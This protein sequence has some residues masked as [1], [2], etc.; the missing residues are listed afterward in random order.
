[1][2][3]SSHYSELFL[4]DKCNFVEIDYESDSCVILYNNERING[5][6]KEVIKNVI[7]ENVTV[8]STENQGS[9]S[10]LITSGNKK[11]GEGNLKR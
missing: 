4:V 10:S 3:S 7:G 5:V 8:L 6:Q 1:M 2:T 9:L 11:V